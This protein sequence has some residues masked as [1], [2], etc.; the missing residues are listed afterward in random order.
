[1]GQ[2]NQWPSSSQTKCQQTEL[3]PLT[4]GSAQL[5]ACDT[6]WINRRQYKLLHILKMTFANLFVR[7]YLNFSCSIVALYVSAAL[8]VQ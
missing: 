6:R 5:A 2:F 8:I 4:N 7:S 3:Q 1:M